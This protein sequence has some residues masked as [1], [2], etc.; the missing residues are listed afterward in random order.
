MRVWVLILSMFIGFSYADEAT[1]PAS[2]AA[3]A[4]RVIMYKVPSHGA[5]A[6]MLDHAASKAK[7]SSHYKQAVEDLKVSSKQRDTW[8]IMCS[9]S[10]T[11][12]TLKYA[13][14]SFEGA[15]L[16]GLSFNLL[17]AKD[18]ACQ[19]EFIDSAKNLGINVKF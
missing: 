10:H 15:V 7:T 14:S 4:G 9:D 5:L 19:Q 11:A 16:S 8:M 3:D 12:K 17:G 6:D 2:Q 13:L 1:T 18:G